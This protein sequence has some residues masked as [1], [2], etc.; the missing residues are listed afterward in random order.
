MVNFI[1]FDDKMG[2]VTAGHNPE[3]PYILDCSF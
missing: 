3:W 1:N 2:E